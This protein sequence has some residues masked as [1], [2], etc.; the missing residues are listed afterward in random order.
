MSYFLVL[1]CGTEYRGF[2]GEILIWI[3]DPLKL[4]TS[5][6]Y[7]LAHDAADISINQIHD[8]DNN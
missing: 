4:I 6:N 5:L 1:L 7:Y 2:E 8:K 3:S